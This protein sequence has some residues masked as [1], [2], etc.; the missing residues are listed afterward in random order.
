MFNF[1]KKRDYPT[2]LF[3][4]VLGTSRDILKSDRTEWREGGMAKSILMSIV[5]EEVK[6]GTQSRIIKME[7]NVDDAGMFVQFREV[8]VEIEGKP[9]ANAA[10][11]LFNPRAQDV[12]NYQYMQEHKTGSADINNAMNQ[13]MTALMQAGEFI[14]DGK[15]TPEHLTQ[16]EFAQLF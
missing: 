6:K 12:Q 15:L 7:V 16:E 8:E 2:E 4:Y 9:K 11:L 14:R 13:M 10:G 1:F 5:S 3:Q